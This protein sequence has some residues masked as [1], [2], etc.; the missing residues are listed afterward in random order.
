VEDPPTDPVTVTEKVPEEVAVPLMIQLAVSKD[1][2]E[3]IVPELTAHDE[4]VPDVVKG[5]MVMA[6]LAVML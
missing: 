6:E 2:P 3:G 4:T 1:K 5:F